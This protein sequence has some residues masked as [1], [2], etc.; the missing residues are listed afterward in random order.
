MGFSLRPIGLCQIAALSYQLG[1]H[2]G[3]VGVMPHSEQSQFIG[4]GCN[5]LSDQLYNLI[6]NIGL[7]VNGDFMISLHDVVHAL[8][9]LRH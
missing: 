2:R 8:S 6:R 5:R 1:R 3:L 4:L 9:T 7:V